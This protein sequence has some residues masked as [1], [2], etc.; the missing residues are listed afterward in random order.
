[1][2]KV[3]EATVGKGCRD[4][5]EPRERGHEQGPSG[6][7]G[8]LI[9]N[10]VHVHEPVGILEEELA[11]VVVE[12]GHDRGVPLVLSL[13]DEEPK[14][15]DRV[16]LTQELLDL[17]SAEGEARSFDVL[18]RGEARDDGLG[19]TSLR[20]RRHVSRHILEPRG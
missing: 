10:S 15:D 3:P 19:R 7:L 2:E 14:K 16:A 4:R 5:L 12:A 8:I 18:A 17:D 13:V 20:A 11:Q 6:R 9:R 1:V